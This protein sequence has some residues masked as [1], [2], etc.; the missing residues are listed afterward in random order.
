MTGRKLLIAV[1][2]DSAPEGLEEAAEGLAHIIADRIEADAQERFL[3]ALE[4][5][6]EESA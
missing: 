6:L 2:R 4:K 3:A 5:V 1:L